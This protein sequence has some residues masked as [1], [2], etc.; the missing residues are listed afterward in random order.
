M[1]PAAPAPR[2]AQGFSTGRAQQWILISALLTATIYVFRRI[3]EPTTGT[4]GAS[5]NKLA[6]LA[7]AGAPP[8]VE[9][10]AIS[11]GAAFLGLAVIAL[12]APEL[13]ASLAVTV[14]LGNVLT[15]GT[16]IA[17]DLGGLEGQKTVTPTVRANSTAAV[18]PTAA[19]ANQATGAGG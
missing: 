11:F 1:V 10:W 8:S 15:N 9:H 2:P 7:G 18:T 19:Q 17:A 13:A 4:S 6:Q 5:S 3:V 14:V 16:T 12:A